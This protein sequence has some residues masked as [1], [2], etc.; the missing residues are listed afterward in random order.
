MSNQGQ[1]FRRRAVRR[2][3]KVDEV[4]SFLDRVEAT[5]NGVPGAAVGAQEVHDVV[6]RVRFGGYDEWQVDLHLD[7]VE[8]QLSELEER[9]AQP[10]RGAELR[11][12]ELRPAEPPRMSPQ[13]PASMGSGPATGNLPNRPAPSPA[14]QRFEDPAFAGAGFD[15]RD[16]SRDPGF[17]PGRH[18]KMDMT[19]EIRMP[20]AGRFNQPAGGPPPSGPPTGGFNG[21]PPGYQ[22][23][24][25]P[26]G[27]QQQPPPVAQ[28]PQGY[29]QPSAPGG[30]G[31][32][33]NA[34]PS[35]GPQGGFN[36]PPAPP[37][38]AAP[39]GE[40]QR[41]DQMRRGFQLRRFGSG[42]DPAQVDRL[43]E[44]VVSALAGHG[45]TP[46]SDNELDP[47][48]FSLV[49]GGYYEGEVDAALREVRDIVRR[50]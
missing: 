33:F 8:R 38:S 48:Q 25:P 4:D 31:G 2:G 47:A 32:G 3:Y 42:Y 26:P 9:A 10:G 40:V 35:A 5:L 6:F 37:A 16:P 23:Q 14:P 20:D 17:D 1:R 24:Q 34:P 21:P 29:G 44:G 28:P 13:A 45:A 43:F 12:T 18:G 22:Q 41:V 49:P 7:R 36:G 19:S 27:Y 11:A 50:R 15:S 46:I 39:T 30:F